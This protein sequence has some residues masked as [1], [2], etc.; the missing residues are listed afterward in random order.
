MKKLLFAATLVMIFIVGCSSTQSDASQEDRFILL[1]N[2][3]IHGYGIKTIQ[4]KETGC[5]YIL[6]TGKGTSVFPLV[7]DD[8]KPLCTNK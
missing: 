1:A 5:Q 7:R 3:G 2:Q 8:G 6:T 4:D